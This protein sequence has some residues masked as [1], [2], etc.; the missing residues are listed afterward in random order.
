MFVS[1]IVLFSLLVCPFFHLQLQELVET[2]DAGA[3]YHIDSALH[4]ACKPVRDKL[5]KTEDA[6][7]AK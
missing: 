1:S 2:A 3:N 5:C 6:G 4:K 7:D